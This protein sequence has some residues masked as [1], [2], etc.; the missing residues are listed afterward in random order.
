MEIHTLKINRPSKN[1]KLPTPNI[2]ALVVLS[3]LVSKIFSGKPGKEC[4]TKGNGDSLGLSCFVK[5]KVQ[6][7]PHYH[8]SVDNRPPTQRW[9]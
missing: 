8:V 1:I 4:Q 9:L 3:P 2:A 5:M 7:R 6:S